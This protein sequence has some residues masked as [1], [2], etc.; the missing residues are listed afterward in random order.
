MNNSSSKITLIRKI[1]TPH[2]NII[3]PNSYEADPNGQSIIPTD[4]I[5]IN[6]ISI[7]KPNTISNP[8]IPNRSKGKKKRFSRLGLVEMTSEMD[9]TDVGV[10]EIVLK[11]VEEIGVGELIVQDVRRQN[12]QGIAII[13]IHPKRQSWV[14]QIE[15]ICRRWLHF[16]LSPSLSFW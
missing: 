5:E 6:S 9:S 7:T 11:G 12:V 10:V 8:N 4:S 2:H 15:E 16:S 13:Q 3:K 14:F 1:T